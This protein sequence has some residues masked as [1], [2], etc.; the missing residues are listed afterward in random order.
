[1]RNFSAFAE[2]VRFSIDNYIYIF[3]RLLLGPSRLV[4]MMVFME[5]RESRIFQNKVMQK[6]SFVQEL[7]SYIYFD[8]H[9]TSPLQL[10]LVPEI[11]EINWQK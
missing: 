7:I 4:E 6:I 11:S 2:R 5:S 8:T 10:V 1:M 3:R 9:Y